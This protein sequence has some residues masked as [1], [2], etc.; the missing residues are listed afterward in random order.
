MQMRYTTSNDEYAKNCIPRELLLIGFVNPIK[1]IVTN[2]YHNILE[3]Y[4]NSTFLQSRAI[5]AST[6]KFVN[7]INDYI[8]ALLPG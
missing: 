6:I 5:L 8:I 7:E 1:K 4:T 2:S 3:S